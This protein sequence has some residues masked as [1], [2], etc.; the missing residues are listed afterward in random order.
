MFC[1]LVSMPHVFVFAVTYWFDKEFLYL[2]FR[3]HVPF[4]ESWG[5]NCRFY[6]PII[7]PHIHQNLNKH[8]GDKVLV[9]FKQLFKRVKCTIFIRF[10]KVLQFLQR[11]Y[12]AKKG[13]ICYE[14]CT[15]TSLYGLAKE[16]TI[17]AEKV[18]CQES[19]FHVSWPCNAMRVGI[20]FIISP[21][22]TVTIILPTRPASSKMGGGMQSNFS[23]PTLLSTALSSYL[24][25]LHP[26]CFLRIR[27]HCIE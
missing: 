1:F 14:M 4:P 5:H 17:F 15:I 3:S 27:W 24:T 18:P 16:E 8:I 21:L 12:S 7:R 2:A 6:F 23:F 19:C 13:K 10:G 25:M 11:K 22:P 26:D 9:H 20:G